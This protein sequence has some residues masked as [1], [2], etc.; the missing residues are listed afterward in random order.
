MKT[1]NT[2]PDGDQLWPQG[3]VMIDRPVG[4]LAFRSD[5]DFFVPT[6]ASVPAGGETTVRHAYALAPTRAELVDFKAFVEDM[7]VAPTVEFTAPA[8]GATVTTAQID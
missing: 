2:K 6:N 7:W 1:N 5:A 8:E 4:E 3:L